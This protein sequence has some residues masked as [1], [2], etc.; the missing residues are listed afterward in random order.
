MLYWIKLVL[1]LKYK[2]HIDEDCSVRILFSTEANCR[3]WIDGS[4]S[5]GRECGR[6]APSPHYAPINQYA[7]IDFKQGWYDV[8]AAVEKPKKD[9]VDWVFAVAYLKTKEL[10]PQAVWYN[11]KG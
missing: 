1:L 5:F 7:D 10:M 2:I 11:V 9:S 8:V 4:Y 3:V 6:M